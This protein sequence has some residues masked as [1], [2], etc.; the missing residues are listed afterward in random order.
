VD[1]IDVW[2]SVSNVCAWFSFLFKGY[3]KKTIQKLLK[4]P[5]FKRILKQNHK[6]SWIGLLIYLETISNML[7][8]K[9]FRLWDGVVKSWYL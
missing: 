3:L 8:N 6:F 9:L 7:S 2:E 4:A 1:L 5:L